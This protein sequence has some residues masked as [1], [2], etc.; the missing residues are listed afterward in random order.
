M[1]EKWAL[2]KRAQYLAVYKSGRAW[3]DGLVVIKGLPNNLE[4]SR[5]GF[6]VTK[7]VGKAVIRNRVKRLLKEIV[8]KLPIESGWDVVFIARPGTADVD[9][10][11][12][13]SSVKGLL[14]RARL[15]R[16]D[17]EVFSIGAN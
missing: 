3:G 7:E 10:H 13:H 6:S 9:Y 2:T 16:D 8:R 12:L 5:F 14:V 11:R 1:A 4:Y 15:L 17:N